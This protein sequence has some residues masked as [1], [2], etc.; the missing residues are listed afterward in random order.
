M[1]RGGKRALLALGVLVVLG[2]GAVTVLPPL[3][4]GDHTDYSK[5]VSIER[6]PEYQ[7]AAL[8]ER[9][10]RLPVAATFKDLEFQHNPSFCG[11]TSAVDVAHSLG[12]PADQAHILDGTGK[13]TVLGLAWGGVNLDEEAHI[14]EAKLGKHVTVL[15]D[16]DLAAFRE[17]ISHA[18][19]PARRYIINF[20]RGP[21]FARG[22]GH[23]SPI[24]GYLPDRDL[25]LVLDV[26][27][28]FKP[29]LV[30][31]DRLFAAMNTV[32]RQTGK[33]RGLL[34]IE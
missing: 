24:G 5:V 29:W 15:R 12:L 34:R 27:Q 13:T 30:K 6:A 22:G 14:V 16:L 2:G 4:F 8:L 3:L 32:D 33:K 9:A 1:T 31:T 19:D 20:S 23:H 25:V 18:N 21:L 17:E 7:D 10:M 26:N 28:H 11:P